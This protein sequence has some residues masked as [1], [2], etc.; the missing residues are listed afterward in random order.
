MAATATIWLLCFGHPTAW[1]MLGIGELNVLDLY[2]LLAAQVP[3][4]GR[5][6][7]PF[8]N[9]LD[10]YHR[11]FGFGFE[12]SALGLGRLVGGNGVARRQLGDSRGDDPTEGLATGRLLAVARCAR[13][14]AVDQ[15]SQPRPGDLSD[16]ELG[17]GML[18]DDQCPRAR[19][20][21]ALLAAA[22]SWKY[23]PLVTLTGLFDC[24]T[25]RAVPGWRGSLCPGA[26]AGLAGTRARAQDAR[27]TR[28]R[29]TGSMPSARRAGPGF[30]LKSVGLLRR[31]RSHGRVGIMA[32]ESVDRPGARRVCP[33]PAIVGSGNSFAVR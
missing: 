5:G 31:R 14:I 12:L 25:R 27:S 24:C 22:P 3:P 19:A 6:A 23:F 4:S 29:P 21:V 20:S 7:D 32:G 1:V 15:S 8:S 10:P 17:P 28:W 11:P 18:S 13:H 26:G 2:A 33:Y 16:L 9:A 30:R